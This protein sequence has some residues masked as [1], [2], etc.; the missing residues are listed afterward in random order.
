MPVQK[1]ELHPSHSLAVNK[2]IQVKEQ[3]RAQAARADAALLDVRRQEDASS[4]LLAQQE[5]LQKQV[6]ETRTQLDDSNEKL[7]KEKTRKQKLEGE[8]KVFLVPECA[9]AYGL[10]PNAIL[11]LCHGCNS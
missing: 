10:Q 9:F 11:F 6:A 7:V 5:G 4:L 2:Y 3:A 1:W 8:N